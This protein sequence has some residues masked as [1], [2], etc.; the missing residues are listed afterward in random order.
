MPDAAPARART[1][2]RVGGWSFG[3]AQLVSGVLAAALSGALG[4]A[5]EAPPPALP[6]AVLPA[7]TAHVPL[8]IAPLVPRGTSAPPA[9]LAPAIPPWAGENAERYAKTVQWAADYYQLPPE[10]LW[11]V[12]KVESNFK[13]NARSRAGALGLMQLMPGTAR[14]LGVSDP[15]DPHQNIFGGA[16]YL[17][18]LANRFAGDLRYT[19]AG[20]NAG[21]YAVKR[22]GGIPPYPET[23]NYVRKVLRYY[24]G[25]P[26]EQM[27]SAAAP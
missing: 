27:A 2:A 17:R 6:V 11:A 21:P 18:L 20:Y 10:L 22:H 5:R 23:I 1:R 9:T 14:E 24:F 4:C 15:F 13:S 12:I 26:S 7:P 16:R 8:R 3:N 25:E 19:L